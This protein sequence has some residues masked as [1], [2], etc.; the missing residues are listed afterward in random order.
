MCF[1]CCSTSFWDAE[2]NT[3]Y[4]FPLRVLDRTSRSCRHLSISPSSLVLHGALACRLGL[5]ALPF[6]LPTD[7]LACAKTGGRP[8]FPPPRVPADPKTIGSSGDVLS[9]HLLH[10]Y[11]TPFC[12]VAPGRPGKLACLN[13]PSL[14]RLCKHHRFGHVTMLILASRRSDLHG[15]KLPKF[16]AGSWT[17]ASMLDQA[18][19]KAQH[20]S[21]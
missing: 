20:L 21:T 17:R 19:I 14:A 10:S 6:L 11:T 15:I 12:K 2:Y 8:A 7:K 16:G 13:E 18:P 4:V 5:T 3:P 9:Q 1:L